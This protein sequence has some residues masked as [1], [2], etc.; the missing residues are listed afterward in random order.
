M[1]SV[2]CLVATIALQ[3][4]CLFHYH[5]DQD[6]SM[7]NYT[8]FHTSQDAIYPS[9]SFCIR[10]PIIPEK[11]DQYEESI[12]VSSYLKFLS[13]KFW[14]DNL[15]T[16][17]YD[18]VT[19][20]LSD[21]LIAGYYHTQSDSTDMWLPQYVVSFRSLVQKCFTIDAP[22]VDNKQLKV[23]EVVVSNKIFPKGQRS[24]IE[25]GQRPSLYTYF[26]YPGQLFMSYHTVKSDWS[27][28]ENKSERYSMSFRIKNI[29]VITNR[30]KPKKR[31]LVDWR[32]HDKYIMNS[33]MND[34]GCR[35][36]YW[37]S[38]AN[39]SFC[40][41]FDEMMNFIPH[42][43]TDR[44]ESYD[45]PCK[46]IERL[47]FNYQEIDISPNFGN[48]NDTFSI[49]QW[50]DQIRFR[51]TIQTK[52]YPFESLVGNM[53]GYMGL[54]LG[55]SLVQVPNLIEVMV[56]VVMRQKAIKQISS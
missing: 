31:C 53:G 7:I 49:K 16:V 35:P 14:D 20:S 22:I 33:V 50:Y 13:G 26:H 28:R 34:V 43:A 2:T 45:P 12:N 4:Y 10:N 21:N 40:Q 24:F 19:V 32:K 5:S 42:P 6:V 51:D 9:F 37:K 27:S 17:D 41:S 56:G 52:A 38:S 30:N 48:M 15:L 25:P 55:Y 36:P 46:H 44:V 18:N 54:F 3:I 8:K 1:G 11:F 39:L 47:D 23:F 29:D